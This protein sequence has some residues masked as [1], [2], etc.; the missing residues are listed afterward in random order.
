[1]VRGEELVGVLSRTDLLR[2]GRRGDG[3]R[4]GSPL[5]VLPN[6][7]VA[8]AMTAP[9]ASVDESALLG[10]AARVMLDHRYHRV[11]VVRNGALVGVLST[12]DLMAAVRDQRDDT[13][14]GQHMSTP[15][16]TIDARASVEDA[17][18]LLDEAGIGGVVVVDGS[19]PIGTYTQADALRAR[20]EPRDTAVEDVMSLSLVCLPT[21][22]HMHRAA[23][24]ALRLGIRRLVAVDEQRAVGILSG[25]DFARCA[26]R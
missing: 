7:N 26:A 3:P 11:Y 4:P 2:V 9:V 5:L 8:S 13:V 20:G 22:L 17:T 6:E 12:R 25:L 15:I 21:G 1:M 16:K 24:Q 18:A 19:W 23:A 10:E 14:V